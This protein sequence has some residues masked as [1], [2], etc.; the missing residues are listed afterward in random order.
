MRKARQSRILVWSLATRS[1]GAAPSV[2]FVLLV[3]LGAGV[4]HSAAAD[5]EIGTFSIVAHDSTT[6][7]LGIAVQSRVYGVGQ[8]VP[9]VNGGVGAIA[10]QANSNESFGPTGLKLLA[11]GLSAQETL[12]WL[13][14]HDPGRDSRQA[15]VVDAS[16]GVANWTGSGCLDWAGDSSGIAFTCQ[17]NILTSN[18]VVAGMARAYRETEGQELARRLIAALHA[19]Q[20]AGGDKRGQQSAAI[21]IGR[22]HPDFPEYAERYVDIRVADHSEPI[23]E[24][25]RLYGMYEAQGLVQAHMRFAATLAAQGDSLGAHRERERV[26]EVLVRVLQNDLRDAGML[27]SLAWFTATHNIYLAQA[28]TAAKRAVEIE[29]ENSNI[30]DTLAE[31]HFRL[32]QTAEAIEVGRRALELSPDDGYLKEQLAKFESAAR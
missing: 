11:T 2:L 25:E 26:G 18:E 29:P 19:A 12:D 16:G 3:L 30:F 21:L 14:A 22:P 7:E 4:L 6:G 8:R 24:L 1:A 31:V 17:R 27:N 20:S 9:W 13:L 5:D 28:L 10:T 23:T 15:G 32:G